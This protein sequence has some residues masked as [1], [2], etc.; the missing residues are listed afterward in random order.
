MDLANTTGNDPH[1]SPGKRKA[2]DMASS[3]ACTRDEYGTVT[4]QIPVKGGCNTVVT[5]SLTAFTNAPSQANGGETRVNVGEEMT[6]RTFAS[7]KAFDVYL[8]EYEAQTFQKFRVRS[9][10]T[11]AA[12]NKAIERDK[13]S[14]PPIPL[15]W[16]FYA[17]TYECTHG[18]VYKAR[19]EG[20]RARQESRAL[21]RKAQV[22]YSSN[23]TIITLFMLLDWRKF[24]QIHFI[25][26]IN[27][28]VRCC[29][30]NNEFILCVTKTTFVHN[31]T[32]SLP[33]F[34]HYPSTRLSILVDVVQTVNV[35]QRAGVK[36]K[37]LVKYIRDNTKCKVVGLDVH[38]LV[39]RL[40]A[41]EAGDNTFAEGLHK[42][43]KEFS[44]EP[45]NIG[46]IFVS[47]ENE[48]VSIMLMLYQ[49]V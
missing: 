44:E 43:M 2:G 48:Q 38:N 49:F 16:V 39:A 40:K 26:Q 27:L 18:G 32:L 20:K 24:L 36:S 45:G 10:K 30:T 47:T 12:R 11:A 3:D 15:E 33:T 21:G 19:G 14:A 1:Q 17:K 29:G 37:K 9:N 5:Q 34:Q 28:C 41:R 22:R 31:H 8:A 25:L 46:R 23:N 6:A 4:E 42:W 13:S 35:L 7:W